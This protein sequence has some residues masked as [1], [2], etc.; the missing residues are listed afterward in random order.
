AGYRTALEETFVLQDLRTLRRFPHFME[1]TPRIFDQ[2][3][4]LARD[5]MRALFL[6]DGTPVKPLRKSMPPT[7]KR[8]GYLNLFKDL[9]RGVRAL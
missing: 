2:Y 7:M 8:V 4:K 5:A 6:V 9:S 1:S 3:P